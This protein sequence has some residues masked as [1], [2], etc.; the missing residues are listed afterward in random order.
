MAA[1]HP[2]TIIAQFK[3]LAP[4]DERA[5]FEQTWM[6]KVSTPARRGTRHRSHSQYVRQVNDRVTQW[7]KIRAGHQD[8]NKF[9]LTWVSHVVE[10]LHRLPDH[11]VGLDK[12]LP[13]GMQLHGP[14]FKPPSLDEHLLHGDELKPEDMYIRPVTVLHPLYFPDLKMCPRDRSHKPQWDGFTTSGPR[15]VYGVNAPELALGYQ[16]RCRQCSA[17]DLKGGAQQTCF[18]TASPQYWAGVPH[19]ERPR[20]CSK[21]LS[22]ALMN[23][24]DSSA[25]V[26][27]V[28]QK[29]AVT[30]AL[31]DW[32]IEGLL[33]TTAGALEASLTRKHHSLSKT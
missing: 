32:I 1:F 6:K 3:A 21:I 16:I 17:H 10:Y 19:W 28:F 30:R 11:L 13:E 24:R 20:E 27:M 9:E 4:Q 26:P 2:A 7:E 12:R 29:S 23:L 31:Y 25:E 33:K 22:R 5:K 15:T 18:G 14:T 8:C